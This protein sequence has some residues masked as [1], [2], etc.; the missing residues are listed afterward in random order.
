MLNELPSGIKISISRSISTVFEQYMEKIGWDEEKYKL[1]E[2]IKQWQFYI[3]NHASWFTKISDE[4]KLDPTFH[5]GLAAKIN[6]TIDKIL[7]DSPTSEQ[8]KKIKQLQYEL[9][10]EHPYSCKAE[11]RYLI[12][13]LTKEIKK[14]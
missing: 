2:F 11:A 9:G 1:E 8:I 5:E 4:I 6:E 7:S 12:N 10:I 13:Y 3:N 14:R